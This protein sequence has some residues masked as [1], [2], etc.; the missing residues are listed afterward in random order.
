MRGAINAGR[1]APG[2]SFHW[3]AT[4]R[5][6]GHVVVRS[7]RLAVLREGVNPQLRLCPQPPAP[8]DPLQLLHPWAVR[9]HHVRCD[10]AANVQERPHVAQGPVQV[11]AAAMHA[12]SQRLPPVAAMTLPAPLPPSAAPVCPSCAR[13]RC[14]YAQGVRKHSHRAVRQQ[15]GRE[16][17][18]GQAQAGAGLCR[19]QRGRAVERHGGMQTPCGQFT[20]WGAHVLPANTSATAAALARSSG[21]AA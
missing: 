16:E 3:P 20:M 19:L 5:V 15:G 18:A 14:P 12:P 11:C 7:A 2:W 1:S 8:P 13:A 4:C 21:G 10:L 6:L 9:H 17:S